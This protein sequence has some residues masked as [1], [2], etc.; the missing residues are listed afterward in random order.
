MP[1]N[2]DYTT[3]LRK[4]KSLLISAALQKRPDV[5]ARQ[6]IQEYPGSLTWE[7][8]D[9][10]MIEGAAWQHV[11]KEM[12]C[13]P[14][15]VFCHPSI[16]IWNK[17]TSLYYRAMAGLSL[18]AARDYV[19][20][21]EKLESGS[22]GAKLDEQKALKIAQTYNLFICSIILNSSGWTLENGHRMIIATMGIS[23]DGTNRNKIG[24][25]AEGR[26][27]RLVVEWAMEHQLVSAPP[28]TAESIDEGLPNS[29][30][31]TG[32]I[33][34]TFSSEP[35][36][37]FR[38]GAELLAVVEIKGGIDPA[39]ALERYGAAQKSFS[40]AVAQSPHCKTFYLTAVTTAELAARI[41]RDRLVEK[42]YNI[43]DLLS[44]LEIREAFLLELFHHTL[45]IT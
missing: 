40:E 6:A 3:D 38:R 19:G 25:V 30:E 45:R 12:R 5:K 10:L 31:L 37:A 2:D 18:K 23:L 1:T 7:P 9:V 42:T 28:L 26:V 15:L 35:D 44:D 21:V 32:N 16:L 4:V 39:G 14:R 29:F 34:M 24:E 27:R 41:A 22:P 36:I 17:T 20:G 8:L 13:D 43:I 11:V 33:Q